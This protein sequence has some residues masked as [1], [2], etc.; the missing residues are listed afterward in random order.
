MIPPLIPR[1]TLDQHVPLHWSTTLV[2]HGGR[3]QGPAC[4]DESAVYSTPDPELVTCKACVLQMGP[5]ALLKRWWRRR[6]M[7][8]NHV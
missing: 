7:G 8:P 1:R 4:E 6:K 2:Y 3:Y 5:I